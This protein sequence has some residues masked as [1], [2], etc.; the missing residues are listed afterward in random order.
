MTSGADLLI[1][2]APVYTADPARPWADA[3]AVRGGQVAATGPER[4][5]AA[6]RGPA[7]RGAAP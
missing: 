4:E 3:V 1:V 6:L 2:G 5:L 7:T